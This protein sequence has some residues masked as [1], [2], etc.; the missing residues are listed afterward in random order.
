MKWRVAAEPII[1]GSRWSWWPTPSFS[2]ISL[3]RRTRVGIGVEPSGSFGSA[4]TS[5]P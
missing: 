3:V 4:G 2:R 5:S 1:V